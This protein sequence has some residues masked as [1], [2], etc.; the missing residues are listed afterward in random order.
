MEADYVLDY[1]LLSVE[2]PH[3]LYVLA[4]IKGHPA[5]QSEARSPLN[6]S[7][8]LDR[9]GSMAGD[10]LA[11]VKEAA[12]FLVRHLGASDRFSLVTYDDHVEVNVPPGPVIFKDSINQAIQAIR[13]G[14]STNLSGGWLKGC[15]MV[16]EAVEHPQLTEDVED[17]ITAGNKSLVQRGKVNRV[18]LLTDGLANQGICDARRLGSMAHQKRDEGVPT[19]TMGVGMDFNEDLLTTMATEGGGNFYFIDNPDKI[20][21]IFAKE[22]QHL[23]DVVGQNL[24]ISLQTSPDAQ[25]I[26][27]L[28]AYP[29][30]R[31]GSDVTFR[32]GDLSGDEIKT[33]LLELS[34]P[35][36]QG[37]GRVEIARLRFD[38]DEINDDQV[39]HRT[40]ELPVEINVVAEED[41]QEPPRDSDVVKSVLIL[42]AAHARK[43]AL[44]HADRGD[45][46]QA[47]TILKDAADAIESAD[48]DDAD[49][50]TEHNLLREEVTDMEFGARRYD[51]HSR[52]LHTSQIFDSTHTRPLSQTM[53]LTEDLK[54]S[55]S[56]IERGGKT[57]A[58][59]KWDKQSLELTMD[60][61]RI[62]RNIDNDIVLAENS[63]SGAH[64]EIVRDGED[65]ILEDLQSTNGT[66]ANRGRLRG[67]FRL[68]VGD[69][70]TVGSTLFRFE[71]TAS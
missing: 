2:R 49:L 21:G 15:Q 26:R 37:L 7:V 67:K 53:I 54:L 41:Y 42:E 62:G 34:V 1:D 16:S 9:S 50:K 13:V 56:A 55:R 10:K 40:L 3:H 12:Q 39:T 29:M 33:L 27:Q 5:P 51:S 19:T 64:C 44:E 66:F 30:S 25:F 69:V 11:R 20:P 31:G 4:R 71:D 60:K 38:Y 35:S 61:L 68:S 70:V 47:T 28:N 52:K 8:V 48:L 36:L 22:L 63:V 18:L 58:V 43:Q 17:D 65:L 45:Y 32:L 57:P 59:L 24:T 6:L 46:Q 23:L 14:G